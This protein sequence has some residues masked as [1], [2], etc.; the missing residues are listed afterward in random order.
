MQ[1]AVFERGEAS[2]FS[3]RKQFRND[4]QHLEHGQDQTFC[5]IWYE[6]LHN[7]YLN[8]FN[9]GSDGIPQFLSC[10]RLVSVYYNH[11]LHAG[12]KAQRKYSRVALFLESAMA[13]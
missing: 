5:K 4:H 10:P 1:F 8:G 6:I 3:R 7:K 11:V 2:V 9:L 13:N 12:R